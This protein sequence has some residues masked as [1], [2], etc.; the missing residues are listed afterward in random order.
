MK[1]NAAAFSMGKADRGLKTSAK[2]KLIFP[3]PGAYHQH[4]LN[5]SQDGGFAVE[6][7][8][9]DCCVD[10]NRKVPTTK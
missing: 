4:G 8:G 6:S 10:C 1:A 9:G 2:S 5:K 7:G 3:G